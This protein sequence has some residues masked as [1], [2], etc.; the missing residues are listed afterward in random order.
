MR[1]GLVSDVHGNI[2][3]LEA[4]LAAIPTDVPLL[5]LGDLVGYGPDPGAAIDALRPRLQAAVLG[6]HDVAA[7]DGY[8]LEL[9]NP[10]AREALEWTRRVLEPSHVAWLDGLAYEIRMP[11][12]LMVHGMPVDYFRYL[13]DKGDAAAAF[14]ATD[15]PLVFVGHTHL[16]E[17]Y[18]LRP[19]G[20]IE[21]GERAS[22]GGLALEPGWR[23]V[24]NPGSVG[25]P[26][27]C[28]PEA[29]YAFYDR[30]ASTVSW[31]RVPY[32]IALVRAK[33]A[34]AGLPAACGARLEVG[35]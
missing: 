29:A 7:I 9:F 13:L 16:A 30:E 3:A 4:V 10:V 18:A 15:A 23:Y 26:R 35:R 25:Q 1:I 21:H 32:S 5:S 6:N 28:N 14:A 12:Y 20:A 34:A 33:I 31:Q 2:E 24:V 22:G 8:G 11:D 19:D 27:D 17:Y